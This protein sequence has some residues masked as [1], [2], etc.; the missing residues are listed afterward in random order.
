MRGFRKTFI[1]NKGLR[2]RTTQNNNSSFLLKAKNVRLSKAGL[3]LIGD[4]TNVTDELILY[5]FP[6]YHKLI[7]KELITKEGKVYNKV[8]NIN[9]LLINT[10]GENTWDIADFGDY[11]ILGNGDVIWE[12]NPDGSVN[13]VDYNKIPKM[14]TFCATHGQVFGANIIGDWLGCDENYA[15]W[16]NISDVT[17]IPDR[18]NEAG[19]RHMEI[20]AINK[21]WPMSD[22]S[23]LF[24]GDNGIARLAPV[25]GNTYLRYDR[26]IRNSFPY[27]GCVAGDEYHIAID[28]KGALWHITTE[29]KRLGYEEWLSQLNL[30]LV[31]ISYDDRLGD[32]YI[33]DGT[34]T[35]VFN[36]NGL[37]EYDGVVTSLENTP[38][39][40]VGYAEKNSS[41]VEVKLCPIDLNLVG[42]K[43]LEMVEIGVATDGDV[44]STS[45]LKY[46]LSQLTTDDIHI[47]VNDSGYGYFG[48]TGNS[49]II[50]VKI[51]NATE[52]NLDFIT[53]GFKLSDNRVQN[54]LQTIS[55]GTWNAG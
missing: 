34:Y 4:I 35:Y 12:I 5:P 40:L 29:A 52:V 51:Q 7:N 49:F 6:Q 2:V 8:G 30:A 46:D 10:Y 41:T 37:T 50:G 26:L 19:F 54:Q 47:R 27:R 45:Q 53:A 11:V 18:K 48:H 22:G 3:E 1:L 21:C 9:T 17:F 25:Q 15:V 36:E 20:G 14:Q 16:S 13:E 28:A 23:V 55:E 33:S 43:S 42:M 44:F 32:F 39:G 24:Y 38:E 31:E